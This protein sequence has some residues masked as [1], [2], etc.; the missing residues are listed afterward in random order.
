MGRSVNE[1][2]RDW[3]GTTRSFTVAW[4]I[5]ILVI[6]AS[7]FAEDSLR[8][9]AW[10]AALAWMGTACLLNAHRCG[11]THCRYT[12]PYYLLL[13]IPVTLH[14]TQVVSLGAPGWWILGIAI[15]AGGT[16]IG[17]DSDRTWGR[18]PEEEGG[19]GGLC[20]SRS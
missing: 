7:A 13:T 19:C 1:L 5:P 10:T 18:Y 16:L 11:S 15:L 14:G 4:G 6:V 2:P 9:L 20:R 17:W 3:V 8:T 12:G